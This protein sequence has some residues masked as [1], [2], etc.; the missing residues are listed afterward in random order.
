M[1]VELSKLAG[2]QFVASLRTAHAAL[3][4]ALGLDGKAAPN[5]D[6]RVDLG[7][8]LR[9]A[10][11]AVSKYALQLVAADDQADDALSLEIRRSLAA[12]DAA[13]PSRVVSASPTPPSPPG[14]PSPPD[15]PT[16]PSPPAPPPVTPTTPVPE[17][18]S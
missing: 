1:E 9:A 17:I 18:P 16:P 8:D 6:T 3:G 2:P 14:P 5:G 12:I 7:A 4:R 13:R 15:P 10:L 11:R